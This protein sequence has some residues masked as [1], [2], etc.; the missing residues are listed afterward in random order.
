MKH[1]QIWL[2]KSVNKENI[3]NALQKL[4]QLIIPVYLY[5]NFAVPHTKFDLQKR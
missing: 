2:W 4:Q 3:G 5:S 1:G